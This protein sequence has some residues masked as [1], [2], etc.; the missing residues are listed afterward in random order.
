ALLVNVP[1]YLTADGSA[2]RFLLGTEGVLFVAETLDYNQQFW[3]NSD[4][5]YQKI[6]VIAYDQIQRNTGYGFRAHPPAL[7]PAEVVERVRHAPLVIVTR[8]EDDGTFFPVLVGGT[9]LTGDNMPDVLYPSADFALTDARALY[10]E[11]KN[12]LQTEIRWQAGE[13]AAV[14]LFVHVYCGDEFIAQSD[15]YPWGDMY[16]FAAWMP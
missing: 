5:L 14:K 9:V 3:M 4:T 7:S 6:T 15:G 11:D 10:H 12:L 13:P 1:D 8:F 2:R 16:P